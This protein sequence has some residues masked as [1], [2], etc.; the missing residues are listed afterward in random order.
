[1]TALER[2]L[3]WAIVAVGFALR[4]AWALYARAEPPVDWFLSG[5]QF[6]YYHYGSEIARGRGYISYITGQATAYYPIGYP[7][8]LGALY[9]VVLHTPI[10]DN[11]LFAT[12][13][14]HV[15]LSTASVALVFV[16]GRAVASTRVG[17]LAA[18]LLAVF[19]NIIYQVATVQL[20]TTFIFLVLAT[21]AVIVTHDWSARPPGTA[22]L[23]AFG[24]TLGIAV[25]VRPFAAVLLVGLAGAL[26]AVHAGGR[27]TLAALALPL[28]V[29]VLLSVPWTLRN[30]AHMHAFIPSS[31][32]MGDTLCID[33]NLDATGGFR[34]AD[35]DGCVDPGL[36][37]VPRNS[38]N[39]KKAIHF[40]LDHPGREAL[41]IVRRARF[42]FRD[43]HDGILAVQT[44]GGGAF[45]SER[46]VDVAEPV[47]D[48]YFYVV[49]ALA[50]AGLPAFARRDRRPARL[51]VLSGLVG[52]LVI[53]LLLWGNPRFH[54]P[55]AP[56]IVLSAALALDAAWRWRPG[57]RGPDAG[58]PSPP[59][60]E[61]TGPDEDDEPYPLI[62]PAADP[63]RA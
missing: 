59:P 17:L 10:P 14:F 38:G 56:F 2:R 22:R 19:P 45:L 26:L 40:V 63:G 27:R 7:A 43:D 25:L 46:V 51:I 16:V 30:A 1:M 58:E 31:T 57:R 13:L 11:L 62:D 8:L 3:L 36:P 28:G 39:T 42:M 61:E 20:E 12:A 53:P 48:W 15:V 55:L 52:L 50:V 9:F 4:L 47:A 49:L 29:V 34:F 37:E 60:S 6:S 24:A 23:L 41:Q 32:N 21:M 18:A 54:L 5:D 33:R 44:L 35:H